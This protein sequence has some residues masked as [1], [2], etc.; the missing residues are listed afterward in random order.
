MNKNIR[1]E[2]ILKSNENINLKELLLNSVESSK[3]DL[4][5]KLKS[6]SNDILQK[7]ASNI[8]SNNTPLLYNG[9]NWLFIKAGYI[10]IFLFR[11]F[12]SIIF[13]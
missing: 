5:E 11:R 1:E 6:S 13:L 7:I 8:K 12:R 3:R 4:M 9:I 2:L 10:T